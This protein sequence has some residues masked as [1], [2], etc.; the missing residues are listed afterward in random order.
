MEQSSGAKGYSS[1]KH[2]NGTELGRGGVW[3]ETCEPFCNTFA[4][5]L[6]SAQE[7]TKHERS[8]SQYTNMVALFMSRV[9]PAYRYPCAWLALDLKGCFY[10]LQS[11]VERG[12]S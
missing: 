1:F 12:L 9:A 10:F 4:K 11:N 2:G 7:N 5:T 3:S 8:N 6:E